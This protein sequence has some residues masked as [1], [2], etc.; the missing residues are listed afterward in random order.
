M[1]GKLLSTHSLKES[2]H[3]GRAIGK[4]VEEEGRAA[5]ERRTAAAAASA[6]VKCT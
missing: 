3:K 5:A 2:R 4:G 6:A 1:L